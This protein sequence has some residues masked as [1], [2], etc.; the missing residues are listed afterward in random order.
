MLSLLPLLLSATLGAPGSTPSVAVLNSPMYVLL[1]SPWRRVRTTDRYVKRLL[2]IGVTR[3]P[4]FASLLAY[5]N[6]TDVIVYIE[7]VPSLPPGLGGRL[8]LLPVSNGQRYLRIEIVTKATIDELVPLIAHELRHAVE[9]A[10]A[11]DVR[12]DSEM[13][14]LYERIGTRSAGDH[15]YETS[16]ARSTAR[17]VRRELVA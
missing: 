4:T 2:Q 11:R 5:L 12:S 13:A 9:V 1:D 10:D 3:S 7:A 8:S 14:K 17:I 6:T 16:A 15:T